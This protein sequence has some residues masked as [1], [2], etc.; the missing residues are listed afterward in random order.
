VDEV[1][2]VLRPDQVA[3]GRALA[4]EF[5]FT[6]VGKVVAGGETRQDSVRNGLAELSPESGVVVIHDGARPF[7]TPQIIASSIDA[8]LA[9]QAAIAAVPVTDTIKSSLDGRFVAST[10]DRGKLYAVQTPQ[11]FRKSLIQSAYESAYADCCYGTDDAS[12]VERL[13]VPVRIVE[14]AYDNIKVTTPTDLAIAEGIIRSRTS[15]FGLRISDLNSQGGRAETGVQVAEQPSP[16]LPFSHSPIL[17]IGHGYD[18]HRFA[19]GRKLYL[20]GVEFP[21]EE[22]LLGHSDADVMLHAVMDAVLGAAGAGDIGRL[23]PETDPAYKD[24]RSTELLSRVTA[25]VAELGWKVGNVDVTLIAERP[26]IAPYV[27]QMRARIAE[28]LGISPDQVSVK[29]STAEGLGPIGEGL[30]I[31]SHAVTLLVRL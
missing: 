28:S 5:G 10:L 6:K 16:I 19:P 3:D 31:E 13:G 9:D 11:T 2:L 25:L 4:R 12:L 30:G 23:F 8:A 17:R 26:R 20:G 21:G 15:D 14:G 1:V 24:V 18:V 22:G 7:V 27:P 29:A